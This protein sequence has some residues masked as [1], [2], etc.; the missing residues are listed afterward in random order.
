MKREL[1]FNTD[2]YRIVDLTKLE[3]EEEEEK[4]EETKSELFQSVIERTRSYT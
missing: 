1:K 4:K 2:Y 3:E